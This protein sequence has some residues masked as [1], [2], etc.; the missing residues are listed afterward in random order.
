M[1]RKLQLMAA[2]MRMS[3]TPPEPPIVGTEIYS[4]PGTGDDLS[5]C[6][7]LAPNPSQQY[8]LDG[9]NLIVEVGSYDTGI[10]SNAQILSI[11]PTGRGTTPYPKRNSNFTSVDSTHVSTSDTYG[12]YST[13]DFGTFKLAV[14]NTINGFDL[15]QWL[16]DNS[17]NEATLRMVGRGFFFDL[18]YFYIQNYKGLKLTSEDAINSALV[19]KNASCV[20]SFDATFVINKSAKTLTP[21]ALKMSGGYSSSITFTEVVNAEPTLA[22][23]TANADWDNSAI[24]KIPTLSAEST[25]KIYH[26]TE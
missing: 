22:V 1:S 11:I 8:T 19:S 10:L 4:F 24:L 26:I 16:S 15:K 20:T 2:M 13:I 21:L 6:L 23:Q 18:P 12:F 5:G 14:R 3:T 25:I 9:S 17:L 7:V